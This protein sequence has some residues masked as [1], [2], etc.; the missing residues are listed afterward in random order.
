M[1]NRFSLLGILLVGL[2]CGA[3]AGADE[4]FVLVVDL[5]SGLVR[6]VSG[7]LSVFETPTTVGSTLKVF[8]AIA[9]LREGTDPNRAVVCPASTVD[10]PPAERCWLVA[11]HG[12]TAFSRAVTHS[13]GVYFR[14]L[15]GTL[16]RSAIRSVY[17][18]Y[19]L[20]PQ[21]DLGKL[22]ALNPEDLIGATEKLRVEPSRLFSAYLSAFAPTER[23][24]YYVREGRI[25]VRKAGP[26]LRIPNRDRLQAA[27]REAAVSG[28]LKTGQATVPSL[29]IF[30]KTGT[31]PVIGQPK[32]WH[33]VFIG[34]APYPNPKHAVL[35]ICDS[36][37]GGGTA[38]PIGAKA[39]ASASLA[40]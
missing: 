36:G 28:T 33:G 25:A 19:G 24:A 34:S 5:P 6:S 2:C 7:N 30:G 20:L 35:V 12:K 38:A 32:K 31:A 26:A 29:P 8:L 1:K 9:A 22:D 37:T 27:L 23:P 4:P 18:D 13:C 16:P 3:S 40:D 17:A 10:T 15:A 21:A 11:G 14:H 39:L